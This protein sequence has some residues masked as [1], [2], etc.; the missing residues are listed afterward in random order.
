M[1]IKRPGYIFFVLLMS[2]LSAAAQNTAP[3][4][5]DTVRIDTI[6]INKYHID[7]PKN[8]IPV[9]TRVL[10]LKQDYMP[11]PLM[12]NYQVNY[13]RKWITLGIN[14]NQSSFSN[15]YVSGGANAMAVG[16]NFE[17]KAEYRKGTFDYVTDL[18]MRYAKAKNK[19]QGARK[20][21]DWLFFDNKIATQ[22]SKSWFFFGSL[23]FQSQFDQGFNYDYTFKDGH[24][25]P[26]VISQFMAPG[27]LTES[28]GFEYK[29]K[30]WFDL[31]IG[32]GTARQT[33]MVKDSL[34]VVNGGNNY[35]VPLGKKFYNDLAFQMVQTTD[36]YLDKGHG[37]HL[38][39]RYALFIPYQ[40]NIKFTSH[41]VDATLYARVT[42]LVNV[43]FNTTFIYDRSAQ[44]DPQASEGLAL[45]INYRFPY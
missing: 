22:L 32:T 24:H 28:V 18:Q 26:A 27:Y 35:G 38:V 20:S 10:G 34:F 43:S 8:A 3:T 42:R 7:P 25:G 30:P 41:R 33:F 39:E 9:R 12:L 19:G 16:G 29:P 11:I 40:K 6:L 17:Y 15:N 37:L 21:D 14:F 13:W 45:G 5:K 4:R 36:A 1:I 23:T 44:R 31:R 2:A